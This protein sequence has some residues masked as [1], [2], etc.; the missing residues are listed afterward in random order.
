MQRTGRYIHKR[1]I[2]HIKA[3]EKTNQIK[4]CIVIYQ[5]GRGD[6]TL[7]VKIYSLFTI[8]TLYNL[9]YYN[10]IITGFG[11]NDSHFRDTVMQSFAKL[12]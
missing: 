9:V 7:V 2:Q 5:L 4:R 12:F 10:S 6:N 1:F 8:I 3:Q 11:K